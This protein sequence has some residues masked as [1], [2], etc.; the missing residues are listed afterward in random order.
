MAIGNEPF[1]Q[2][3]KVRVDDSQAL[4]SIAR[5]KKELAS[6]R[7]TRLRVN[8]NGSVSSGNSGSVGGSGGYLI[9]EQRKL[10]KSTSHLNLAF[11]K[12]SRSVDKV[13]VSYGQNG[14]ARI[15]ANGG[16]KSPL[17]F[18]RLGGLAAVMPG[19]IQMASMVIAPMKAMFSTGF[20]A[21]KS[22]ESLKTDLGTLLGNDRE[23]SAFA[24]RI[25]QYASDTPYSERDLSGTAK[26]LLQYGASTDEAET[27]CCNGVLRELS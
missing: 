10:A 27:Y 1:V 3:F 20:G 23:G 5:I 7:D 22:F 13:N 14:G 11:D 21:L 16:Y 8:S 4:Q 19:M 26:M 25:R 15:I 24:E 6:L 12:L 17:P 2:T 18:G 9:H